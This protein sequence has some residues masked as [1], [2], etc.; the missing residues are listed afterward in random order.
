MATVF[1]SYAS[2][3]IETARQIELS[4]EGDGHSVFVDRA[5]LPAGESF[6][7]RIRAAIADSDLLVFLISAASVAPG[8]YTLTELKFAEEKWGHPAGHVLPVLVEPVAKD[9]IP[10]YL[11]AVT[12]LSPRGNVA[13]EVSAAV[14]RLSA[15]WWRRML[16]PRRLV[17]AL[18]AVV[19]LAGTAW[20][21]VPSYLESRA[22]R[23]RAIALAEQSE[24]QA[25]AA[26]FR[27]ADESLKQA[28]GLAPE[29]AEVIELDERRAMARLRSVGVRFFRGSHGDIQTLIETTWP[30]LSH[31]VSQAKGERLANLLAHMGWAESLRE[32]AGLGAGRPAEHYRR[33]LEIDPRNVYAHA[34]WGFE[35]LRP[36]GSSAALEESRRHFAAAIETGRERAYVRQVQI[37]ALLQTDTNV[38]I[39]DVAREGEAL[40]VVNAMRVTGEPRPRGWAS[41][42]VKKTIWS[43]YHFDVVTRDRLEP[44]LAG[45]PAADH[46]ATFRWLFPED[47]LAEGDGAPI[48]FFYLFVLGRLQER[49]GEHTA[50]LT[51]YRRVLE[52]A[53]I[54]KYDSSQALAIVK[55]VKA[56][57]KRL[58]G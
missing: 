43:I 35:L 14:A 38:W 26:D 16:E 47:D 15:S 30:T 42:G 56:A 12:I 3:Q 17:P 4:L 32:R 13:A 24:V 6:D 23:A 27:A 41:G 11:R 20:T 7:A 52:E 28:K 50:A 10:A 22:R 18:I 45:L 9:A 31:G 53:T 25:A 57:V 49:S 37:G 34:M 29:A 39:D 33:A 51:S 58:A 36:R 19:V 8:R 54:K 40:R 48:P 44:L 5:S 21:V 55:N 46:L 2:E 1:L